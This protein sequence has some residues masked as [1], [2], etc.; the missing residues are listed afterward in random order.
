[1][2]DLTNNQIIKGDVLEL[3][4]ITQ[5]TNEI[6]DQLG[7]SVEVID[8]IVSKINADLASTSD[9]PTT[10][11]PR[12]P[13]NLNE[14]QVN[15]IISAYLSGAK[16]STIVNAHQTSVSSVY[17]VLT[18]HGIPLRRQVQDAYIQSNTKLDEAMDMYY[19]GAKLW[20]IQAKTGIHQP[21]LHLAIH[22]AGLST[23]QEYLKRGLV[24]YEEYQKVKN[25]SEA[26][27]QAPSQV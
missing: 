3:L 26:Q 1:M 5:D 13:T 18:S 24:P 10:Q 7:L 6:A 23:R 20:Q 2:D 14:N 12:T 8:Q 11:T 19:Q 4:K 9:T 27:G 22:L 25:Q 21:T 15:Q 17:R 16:V